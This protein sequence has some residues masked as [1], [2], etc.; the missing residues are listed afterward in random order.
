MKKKIK[1]VVKDHKG[2]ENSVWDT[3]AD[4]RAEVK[5]LNQN[6]FEEWM[7]DV[8]YPVH[9]VR[10]EWLLLGEKVVR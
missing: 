4:A 5:W 7:D 9:I 1:W 3:R 8:E 6:M 10:E 2:R